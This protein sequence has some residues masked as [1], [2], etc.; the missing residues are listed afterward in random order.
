M[1]L[2][3][4]WLLKSLRVVSTSCEL[5]LFWCNGCSY[6]KIKEILIYQQ[7]NHTVGYEIILTIT[8]KSDGMNNSH[9]FQIKLDELMLGAMLYF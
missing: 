8:D 2:K 7:L 1:K 3:V 5:L 9:G 6:P 4:C